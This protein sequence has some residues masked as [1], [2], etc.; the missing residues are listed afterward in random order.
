MHV[1]ICLILL[2]L[3]ILNSNVAMHNNDHEVAKQTNFIIKFDQWK[4]TGVDKLWEYKQ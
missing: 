4:L 3:R 2:V 1:F